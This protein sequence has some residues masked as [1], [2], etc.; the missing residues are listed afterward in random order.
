MGSGTGQNK[1]MDGIVSDHQAGALL[2]RGG[3]AWTGRELFESVTL[4]AESSLMRK[5][6]LWQSLVPRKDLRYSG[7]SSCVR[8]KI[9]GQPCSELPLLWILGDLVHTLPE[10]LPRNE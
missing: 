8:A 5:S 4:L 3:Q 7:N 2:Y 10:I 6:Q 1:N 9:R